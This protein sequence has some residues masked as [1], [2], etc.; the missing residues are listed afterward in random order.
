MNF[1]DMFDA[2][3]E[4]EKD[5]TLFERRYIALRERERWLSSDAEVSLLPVVKPDHPHFKEWRIRG[6]S[7]KR[8]SRYLGKKHRPLNILEVGCGNGWLSYHLAK[9]PYSNVTGIDINAIELNQAKRVFIYRSNLEFVLGD[10]RSEILYD[11][12]YDVVVFAASVQYFHCLK[13]MIEFVLQRLLN[14]GGEIHILDSPFYKENEVQ[15][16]R[17]RTIDHYIQL[18]FPEMINYYF[19]HNLNE[20]Q[21]FHY[22]ILYDPGA[23]HFPFIK[24]RNPFYLICIKKE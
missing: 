19:H 17:M 11:R 23:L 9:L 16:A 13:E 22:K 5:P 20:L 7:C 10:I 21:C 24:N 14:P 12:T 8:L 3:K 6:R 4:S 1:A 2:I 15:A 18:G